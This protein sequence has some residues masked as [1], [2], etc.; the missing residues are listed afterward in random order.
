MKCVSNE[1]NTIDKASCA[2]GLQFF[3]I[4]KNSL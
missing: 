4:H 3:K 1:S 2:I